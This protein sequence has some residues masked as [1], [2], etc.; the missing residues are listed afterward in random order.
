MGQTGSDGEYYIVGEQHR[1]KSQFE[2]L[3]TWTLRPAPENVF[4]LLGET[5]YS[6]IG[7]GSL[8]GF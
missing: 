1:V 3:V 8:L 7:T 4:W 2:H 5:S 6:E